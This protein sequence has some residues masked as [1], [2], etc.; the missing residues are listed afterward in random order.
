MQ[1]LPN[2]RNQLSNKGL[3]E[4]F[5]MQMIKDFEQSNFPTDFIAALTPDYSRIYEQIVY[6]LQHCEKKSDFNLSR[7]LNRIDISDAQLKKYLIE[8]KNENHFSIIAEL[9]IKRILQ[10]VVIRQHYK[11]NENDL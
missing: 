3:F 8:H 11:N 2:I 7:L 6:E 5:K 1:K 10:K 9:I 4:A